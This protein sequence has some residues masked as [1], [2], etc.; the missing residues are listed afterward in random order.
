MSVPRIVLVCGAT[1]QTGSATVAA[2]LQECKGEKVPAVKVLAMVRDAKSDSALKLQ[3]EGAILVTGNFDDKKSLKEAFR[4]VNACFLCCANQPNQVALESNVIDA[5]E[6]SETCAYLVKIGT[7]GI[8]GPTEDTPD[9][10]SLNSLVEYGRFHAAIEERLSRCDPSKLS[11]TCLR[12]NHFMQNHAGDIFGTLPK[13]IIVYPHTDAKA[14]I[15][16]TRDVGEISAKLLLLEDI[17]K[18]SGKCYDVC[19][20]KGW[21]INELASLYTSVLGTSIQ[22]VECKPES[23]QAGMVEA[24]FPEWLAKAITTA[25]MTFWARGATNYESSPA[26]KELHPH[27]RTMEQWVK[28]MASLVK[29]DE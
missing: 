15:V 9:Y 21:S 28:E 3:K 8:K 4:G 20:P 12:P 23:F 24:G 7:C 1:G 6:A 13:K 16:D 5:A 14:T 27:F 18:H 25:N 11:W 22:A 2:L 29:F 17:S 26:I 19:G 10:T